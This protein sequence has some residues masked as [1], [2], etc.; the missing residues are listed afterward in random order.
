[1]KVVAFSPSPNQFW[2]IPREK[3]E[4][5]RKEFPGVEFISVDSSKN[6]AQTLQNAD[7]F[8]GYRLPS[9]ELSAAS[10]L[11]WI[12][13][14][15]ANV[16]GFDTGILMEKKIVLTNSRGQH[17]VPIAEHVIGCM[18]VFSRR[19]LDSWKFQNEC[20][21]AQMEMINQPPPLFELRGKTVVILG[22]GGIG[23]ELA[24][25]AKAFGMRVLAIKRRVDNQKVENVDQILKH[26][27]FRIALPE[28]DFLVISAAR[29][30]E[31]EGMLGES[32][33]ALLKSDSVI[34]NIARAQIIQEKALYRVLEEHRIRGAALDV[35]YQ[36]PLL[37]DSPLFKF[38][39]VF[40]TPHIAG[41][42]SS[43]HWN[44][45]IALFAE[46]LHR[47]QGGEP[48]LNIVD[49]KAGY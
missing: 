47:F 30:V 45:M 35:F 37:P 41:V 20:H 22:L 21:Y 9:Q 43:E 24:R 46:N 32:E 28:A 49:L 48:L 19:F 8:F 1:M 44:R 39:N 13:V 10:Q 40:L 3:L 38:D 16:Y 18:L 29:T 2:R 34:I 17:A 31:T 5:L 26:S 25:L 23:S 14:P 27:D 42:N 6:L 15:A 33:L 4:A 11:K 12:H 7:V 36:E